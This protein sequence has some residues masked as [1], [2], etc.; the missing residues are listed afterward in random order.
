MTVIAWD[1]KTLAADKRAESCGMKRSRTKIFRLATGQLMGYSG[2]TCVGL[3]MKDW[4][5]SGCL[6]ESFP[7]A[8]AAQDHGNCILITREGVV[9][10]DNTRFALPVSESFCA[11]GSGRDYAVAAM[12]L[13]KSSREAVE[14]ASM[15]DVYCGD[16]VDELTLD[17][18]T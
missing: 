5:E 1:G 14:I 13:G 16:G 8:Q 3:A 6:P 12:H 4:I 18:P 17:A 10:Y 7:A 11:F 15:F 2:D 9:V